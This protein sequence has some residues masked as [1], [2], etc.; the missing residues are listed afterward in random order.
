MV[1]KHK[2][3]EI[4]RRVNRLAD[5]WCLSLEEQAKAIEHKLLSPKDLVEASFARIDAL[6]ERLNTTVTVMAESAREAADAATKTQQQ[7]ATTGLLHGLPI[8]L[9]DIFDTADVL[10][11]GGSKTQ[12]FARSESRCDICH[13]AKRGRCGHRG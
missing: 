7:G 2:I 8:G 1:G 9:K 3:N 13:E 6:D 5:I 11:A 4:V 12:D 10:T